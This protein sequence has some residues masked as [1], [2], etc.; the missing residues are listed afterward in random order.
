MISHKDARGMASAALMALRLLP[1]APAAAVQSHTMA[2][3]TQLGP[4]SSADHGQATANTGT[5]CTPL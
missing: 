3:D 5:A 4:A 2:A 1:A